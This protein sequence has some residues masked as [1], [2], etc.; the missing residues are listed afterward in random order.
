MG[1]QS[2]EIAVYIT[3]NRDRVITGNALTLVIP[4]ENERKKS[5]TDISKALRGNVLQLQNGD[6]LIIV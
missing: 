3:T 1:K 6:Y 5:V 4:D 2:P